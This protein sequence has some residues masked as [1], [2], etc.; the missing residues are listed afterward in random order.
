MHSPG[1]SSERKRSNKQDGGWSWPPPPGSF[2]LTLGLGQEPLL[3]PITPITR[4]AASQG[5]SP[6]LCS[7]WTVGTLRAV[8]TD[9][10]GG[11]SGVFYVWGVC[12][13]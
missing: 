3:A 13:S 12:L 6:S 11:H 7:H 4:T 1:L 10:L 9:F 8:L 5:M 2:L